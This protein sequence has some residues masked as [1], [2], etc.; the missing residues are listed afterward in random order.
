MPKRLKVLSS[1]ILLLLAVMLS[2]CVFD[3]TKSTTEI[4]PPKDVNF[5]SEDEPLEAVEDK[6]EANDVD[7]TTSEEVET[8]TRQLYLMDKNGYV[9]PQSLNLPKTKEVA[10]QAVE[11]LVKDGP[12]TD[13]LPNGFQ[14]VLPAGTEVIGVNLDSDTAIVDFS[15]EF[16]DYD[17]SEEQKILQSITWT[18]TQFDNIKN[19]QIW[20]NGYEQKVM[21]VNQ[22]PVGEGVSRLDGI[23]NETGNVV[24]MANSMGVTVYYLAQTEGTSYYVPVTKRIANKTDSVAAVV[25]GL[26][27]GPS[28]QSGLFSDF[29]SDVELLDVSIDD[30]GL[31]TLNFNE[32]LLNQEIVSD[33]TLNALVLSLTEQTNIHQVAIQVNGEPTLK[34]ASGEPLAEPVTREMITKTIGF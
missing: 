2:G 34:N 24:D 9:V 32:A 5:V 21:P 17:P 12:V 20:I 8:V 30:V 14:A 10:K 16:A 23:N 31:A 7:E 28:I 19:V 11:Y 25:E 15:K 26:V 22:T 33:H 27:D 6:K 1:F 3:A 18:L 13:L 4:D 29:S